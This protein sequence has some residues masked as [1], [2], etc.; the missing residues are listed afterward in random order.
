M[1]RCSIALN[2]NAESYTAL[3]WMPTCLS[4]HVRA[5][6]L[7]SNCPSGLIDGRVRTRKSVRTVSPSI[8]AKQ[9]HLLTL[10]AP[11]VLP[12][13]HS[14]QTVR[15]KFG[16]TSTN[17]LLPSAAGRLSRMGGG[18]LSDNENSRRWAGSR[19]AGYWWRQ[20]LAE[21]Q[22]NE[23]AEMR[24]WRKWADEGWSNG[25]NRYEKRTVRSLSEVEHSQ[26]ADSPFGGAVVLSEIR[27]LRLNNP[28]SQWRTE[29][30]AGY[31]LSF[32]KNLS[33]GNSYFVFLFFLATVFNDVVHLS[34]PFCSQM[35]YHWATSPI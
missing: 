11:L 4:K 25:N 9:W 24:N 15:T 32:L 30:F 31:S 20:R 21:R 1:N 12:R 8:K 5:P 35:V 26:P 19:Q 17:R 16:W 28:N 14:G 3:S 33:S 6:G 34:W 10:S 18:R 7:S 23:E 2:T 13:L 22:K 27:I 29:L